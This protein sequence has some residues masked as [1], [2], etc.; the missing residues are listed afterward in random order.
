MQNR[1]SAVGLIGDHLLKNKQSLYQLI[2]IFIFL[3]GIHFSFTQTFGYC[4]NSISESLPAEVENLQSTR[5]KLHGEYGLYVQEKQN[6]IKVHW[7]TA[8]EDSGFLK[9]FKNGNELF[10]FKTA[11]ARAHQ[12]G[13]EI[14]NYRAL[15]LQYGSLFDLSDRHET[16]I[17]FNKVSQ[18][19]QSEFSRID[20][21]YVLGDIHGEFDTLTNLLKNATVIDSN[22]NWIAN[23]KHLIALGDIFD[24]GH[25]VTR[26]LWFLYKLEKQANKQGGR[27]HVVLGNHEIMIFLNDLRYLSGKENLIAN[28]HGVSYAEMYSPS[29]S[30]LGNW[31]SQKPAILKID[32]TIFAHGGVTPAYTA[33]SIP[34]INDSLRVFLQEDIF[35]TL[36]QDSIPAS[37]D[38]LQF[39]RRLAFFYAENSLFWHRGYVLSDTL[40]KDLEIILKKF[41]SKLHVVAHT[42][43][44]TIRELYNGKIVAVDLN[45][46]A[47]E[48]L[49]LVRNGK[50]KVKRFRIRSDG[51]T[52]PL[53]EYR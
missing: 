44:P 37:V 48:M 3:V 36:L 13:F 42:P 11:S 38:S 46:P 45:I 52:E 17:Y 24:R 31:L 4:Q 9:I 19:T 25:D 47:T 23:Q 18:K 22:Y 51:L 35:Y 29:H 33:L 16:V 32:K 28:S 26:T 10:G 43:V 6:Q 21:I 8:K 30:L 1:N 20:S 27:V 50:N 15:T 14:N 2:P 49:L 41:K 12:A 53:R 34:A 40:E 39:N 5:F 7:M